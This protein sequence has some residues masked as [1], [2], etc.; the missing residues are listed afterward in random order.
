MYTSPK[1]ALT[2][3]NLIERGSDKITVGLGWAAL[4]NGD[5]VL[6]SAMKMYAIPD[7]IASNTAFSIT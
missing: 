4:S 7:R 6:K 3:L 2:F 1:H 5:L